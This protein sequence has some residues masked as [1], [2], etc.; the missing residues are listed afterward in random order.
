MHSVD[1]IQ[2]QNDD[3]NRRCD[4]HHRC[5]T[6]MNSPPVLALVIVDETC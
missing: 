4:C 1:D 5:G 2:D 6:D 3:T